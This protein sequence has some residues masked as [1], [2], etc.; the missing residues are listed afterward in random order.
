MGRGQ[1]LWFFEEHGPAC[2]R[3]FLH[4]QMPVIEEGEP[5]PHP[6]L[7]AVLVFDDRMSSWPAMTL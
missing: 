3:K 6:G 7:G 2:G 5:G 1:G 4:L